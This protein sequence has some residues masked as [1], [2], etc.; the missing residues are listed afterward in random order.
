MCW[1]RHLL[2]L[3]YEIYVIFQLFVEKDHENRSSLFIAYKFPLQNS[4]EF[5]KVLLGLSTPLRPDIKPFSV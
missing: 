2:G 5:A 3:K 4:P 1:F